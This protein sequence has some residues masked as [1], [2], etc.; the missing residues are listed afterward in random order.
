[1]KY[2][3]KFVSLLLVMLLSLGLYAGCTPQVAGNSDSLP[4]RIRLMQ[5]PEIRI[6]LTRIKAIQ[7]RIFRKN[8]KLSKIIRYRSAT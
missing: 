2:A 8:K 3:N 1:M 6:R 7:T 5:L 4:H